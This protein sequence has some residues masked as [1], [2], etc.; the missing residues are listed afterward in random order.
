VLEIQKKRWHRNS[1]EMLRVFSLRQG[2]GYVIGAV[3]RSFCV[4]LSVRLCA[5]FPYKSNQPISLKL[6]VTIGPTDRKNCLTFGGDPVPDTD[7]ESLFH[8]PHHC[9]VGDFMR[10][11]SISHTVARRRPI[12]TTLGEMTNAEW[13]HNVLEAI[14][15]TS[16]NEQELIRKPGFE[17]LITFG[18]G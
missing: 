12:F 3:C 2:K 11:I 10:F 1:Y 15:K 13:I 7:S 8:F 4:I 6:R 14:W 5:G 18:W 16:G 17:S 9:R